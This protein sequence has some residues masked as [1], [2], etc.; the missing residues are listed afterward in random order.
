MMTLLD[1]E[2]GVFYEIRG[3]YFLP[4]KYIKASTELDIDR[5][6]IS[7]RMFEIHFVLL[8]GER[9]GF[10]FTSKFSILNGGSYLLTYLKS[11]KKA[12]E[13]EVLIKTDELVVYNYPNRGMLAISP[14]VGAQIEQVFAEQ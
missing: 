12:H 8:N 10:F 5:A 9:S 1:S 2:P 7:G 4:L 14:L 11:K 13:C 6:I 3:G